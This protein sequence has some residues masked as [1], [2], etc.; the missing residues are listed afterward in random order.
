MMTEELKQKVQ[1]A[2][3]NALPEVLASLI[4]IATDQKRSVRTRLR[5]AELIL[6]GVERG[7]WKIPPQLSQENAK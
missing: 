6:T 3:R 5:A 1:T 4:E 7:A 2:F